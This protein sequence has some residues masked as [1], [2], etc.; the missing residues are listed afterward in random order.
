MIVNLEVIPINEY[1]G[2]DYDGSDES[3]AEK[4]R[5][6]SGTI[7]RIR[8]LIREDASIITYDIESAFRTYVNIEDDGTIP[9]NSRKTL[10]VQTTFEMKDQ[11]M[12]EV[13]GIK[14]L[15]IIDSIEVNWDDHACRISYGVRDETGKVFYGITEESLSEWVLGR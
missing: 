7:K 10:T 13:A 12:I 8:Y 9:S 14:R 11:V 5:Y 6:Q 3:P 1:I 15:G 4:K 2:C